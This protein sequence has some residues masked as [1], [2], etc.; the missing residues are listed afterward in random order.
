MNIRIYSV[1]IERFFK[2]GDGWTGWN[3]VNV[4]L[5]NDAHAASE[6]I[7]Q[8]L[9]L[10]RKGVKKDKQLRVNEVRFIAEGRAND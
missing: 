7:A 6:A 3:V 10:C 1:H 4:A 5:T 2:K 8:G 9:E